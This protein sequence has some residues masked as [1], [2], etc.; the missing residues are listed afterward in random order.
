MSVEREGSTFRPAL[1]GHPEMLDGAVFVAKG[2]FDLPGVAALAHAMRADELIALHQPEAAMHEG[3]AAVALAADDP[4]SWI[5]YADALLA[6]G[7][8]QEARQAVAKA[9]QVLARAPE[10]DFF[11]SGRL[12]ESRRRLRQRQ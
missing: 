12:D 1:S 2:T 6:G 5:S 3:A 9:E 11:A 4:R 7:R 10:L 8:T